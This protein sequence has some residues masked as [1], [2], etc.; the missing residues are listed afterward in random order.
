MTSLSIILPAYNEAK[1][2]P[3]TFSLIKKAIKQGVFDQCDLQEILV[4]D[5]GSKDN[6]IQAAEAAK[7]ELPQIR[8]VPIVPNAG[9][10]NAIHTGLRESRS[11]WCLI[12]DADSATP[13]DQFMKLWWAIQ[14]SKEP[15]QIAIGSRDLPESEIR[16]SQS[17]L[18]EH[19]GK[20]FNLFVRIIT[21]LPFK[22]TQCGFK[23]IH[24]GSIQ[25]FISLLI[26][27]RFAWDVEFLMFARVYN[28]NTVEVAVAWE[29]QD[30]SRVSKLK[31]S[32]EMLLRVLQMRIRL[33]F[34]KWK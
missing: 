15:T 2:L 25:P 29:H 21:G 20:T 19:M 10:G 5:D 30:D 4:V 16:T 34:L 8:V 11:D 31:D 3:R 18:R 7:T 17:W 6:T 23:L 14:K 13:W 24:R 9:K 28:L 27:K 22:D 26:V 1:R 12:A 33:F 32:A